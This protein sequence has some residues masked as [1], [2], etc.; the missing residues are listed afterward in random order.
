[1]KE[2]VPQDA[3]ASPDVLRRARDIE[4]A[5]RCLHVAA[6]YLDDTSTASVAMAI[7]EASVALSHLE[8]LDDGDE[9][10][11]RRMLWGGLHE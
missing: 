5:R 3:P 1:M 10:D 7:L 9:A 6:A 2:F 4:I 8:S 11:V